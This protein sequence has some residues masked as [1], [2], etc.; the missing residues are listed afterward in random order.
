M[1]H[2]LW[3]LSKSVFR[4][5]WLLSKSVFR[6]LWLLSRSV[7]RFVWSQSRS[8]FR[9]SVV[10]VEVSV[11][12]SVVTVEVSLPF[13]V[14]LFSQVD[15]YKTGTYCATIFGQETYIWDTWPGSQTALSSTSSI[16]I[17]IQI[18]KPEMHNLLDK[19]MFIINYLRRLTVM[20]HW[21]YQTLLTAYFVEILKFI[22]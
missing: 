1:A 13:S 5:L 4:V 21:L 10:T 20:S 2:S 11:P 17:V 3:L 19:E 12:C 9:F 14:V 6:V 22:R 16:Q 7:F 15:F 8:V 18:N